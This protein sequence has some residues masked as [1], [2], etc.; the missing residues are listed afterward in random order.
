MS[1]HRYMLMWLTVPGVTI[2]AMLTHMNVE[3]QVCADQ[4]WSS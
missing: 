1:D 4:M 3:F 2:R